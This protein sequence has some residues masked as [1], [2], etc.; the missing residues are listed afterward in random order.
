MYE[1][2]REL[3]NKLKLWKLENIKKI[4]GINV[5]YPEKLCFIQFSTTIY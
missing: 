2:P 3:P 1:L 5:T 4:L